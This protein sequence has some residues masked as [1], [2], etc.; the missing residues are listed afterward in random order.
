MCVKQCWSPLFWCTILH[1]TLVWQRTLASNTTRLVLFW[2]TYTYPTTNH[3]TMLS[4]LRSASLTQLV[5]ATVSQKQWLLTNIY[6][7]FMSFNL[8]TLIFQFPKRSLKQQWAVNTHTHT[9]T[10]TQSEER[11][12]YTVW[13]RGVLIVTEISYKIN[14]PKQTEYINILYQEDRRRAEYE[15]SRKDGCFTRLEVLHLLRTQE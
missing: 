2:L 5:F 1:G 8:P 14:M 12:E 10:H 4:V 9:H 15:F 6:F 7:V 11:K 3:Q 13:E